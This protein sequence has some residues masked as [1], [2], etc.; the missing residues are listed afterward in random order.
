MSCIP[1]LT[2]IQAMKTLNDKTVEVTR[3]VDGG[4]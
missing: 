3:E 1:C 4:V 2:S